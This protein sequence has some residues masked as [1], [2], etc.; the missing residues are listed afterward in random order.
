MQSRWRF[1]HGVGSAVGLARA[2]LTLLEAFQCVVN[3]AHRCAHLD[4]FALRC[5]GGGAQ[6]TAVKLDDIALE[7]LTAEDIVP[8]A[9]KLYD[10]ALR[11]HVL[12]AM[13][14]RGVIFQDFGNISRVT[15]SSSA[16]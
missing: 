16:G 6:S 8:H 10:I 15:L 4:G 12:A 5:S 2:R 11:C 13:C 7:T 14:D 9:V 3:L 1:G